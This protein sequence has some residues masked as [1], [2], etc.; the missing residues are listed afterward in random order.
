ML[1]LDIIHYKFHSESSEKQSS[2]NVFL[3]IKNFQVFRAET[4]DLTKDIHWV[5]CI[6]IILSVAWPKWDL[7]L[8]K[9]ALL[10]GPH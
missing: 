6:I 10:S 9:T 1:L 3:L 8:S 7:S 2:G 5:I 4:K